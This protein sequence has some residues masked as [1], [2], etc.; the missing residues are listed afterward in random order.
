[1][2]SQYYTCT[3]R[4][5]NNFDAGWLERYVLNV[6]QTSSTAGADLPLAMAMALVLANYRSPILARA[7]RIVMVTAGCSKTKRRVRHPVGFVANPI[8]LADDTGG[9]VD[10]QNNPEVAIGYRFQTASGQFSTRTFRGIRDSW[11]EE[12]TLLYGSGGRDSLIAYNP[13]LPTIPAANMTVPAV[14]TVATGFGAALDKWIDMVAYY[15]V[16]AVTKGQPVG[17][18][19]L[20]PYTAWYLGE[21]TSRDTGKGYSFGRARAPRRKI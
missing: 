17:E 7:Y 16:K 19:N 4:I 12:D 21:V 11:I 15:T 9:A 8:V 18:A 2:S 13:A 14:S 5:N 20:F 6:N 10:K 1:M 3:F